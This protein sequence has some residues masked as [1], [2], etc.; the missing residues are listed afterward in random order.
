MTVEWSGSGPELALV[1]DRARPLG[2]QLQDAL[3][4]AVRSGRLAP[5]EVLPSSR[6]LAA[7][8]GLSRGLV[9]QSYEQLVAE[10]Y[11]VTLPGGS[12]RAATLERADPVPPPPSRRP[13]PRIDFVLGRP[14]LSS[15]PVR[16]W[17]RSYAEAASALGPA[18]VGYAEDG[19]APTL[20]EVLAAYARRVRAASASAQQVIVCAG[21]SQGA[22]L[23]LAVLRARGVAHVALEDPGHPHGPTLVRRAGLSLCP[24]PVDDR[25]LDVAALAETPARAV[26]VTP[27]HQTP[28]GVVLAPE[29]RAALLEWAR[30]VDGYV[31]E[32]DY[33][34]EFRYDRQP[35]GSL[36]GM[37][38]DHVVQVGSVSKSLGPALRLGWLV[39]PPALAS[40]LVAEKLRADRGSP[41]IDQLALARMIESGRFDRHLR[42]VRRMY[43]ARRRTLVDALAA[44][45]PTAHL[46]GLEAGF[47]ALLPLGPRTSEETVITEAR[48][49]GVGL[50]GVAR[51][52]APGSTHPPALVLGF[53]DLRESQITEG[54][55]LVA[56]LISR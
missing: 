43:T 4:D 17:A 3:R 18:D 28:T 33:D 12:T 22:A 32:D 16:D 37:A 40:D 49:R 50:Q 2:A 48:Q 34:S 30:A 45:A 47:H 20:R 38:P 11:L 44:H 13:S 8:L 51:Y 14:D 52:A 54:V 5:G 31:L 25:G 36:Q 55:A 1:L 9:Q 41:A 39:A 56:P 29:R 15:F 35:V 42:R 6:R 27:A 21:F 24:V 23:T 7:T 19:G 26:L 53:G 46:H 10:G